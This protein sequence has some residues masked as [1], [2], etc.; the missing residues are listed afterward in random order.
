MATGKTAP[1]PFWGRDRAGARELAGRG[2]QRGECASL[3]DSECNRLLSTAVNRGLTKLLKRLEVS[4]VSSVFLL[5]KL[6]KFGAVVVQVERSVPQLLRI[7][8]GE[9]VLAVDFDE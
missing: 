2:R 9:Q 6:K 4:L 3:R 1:P 7:G 5:H 8:L